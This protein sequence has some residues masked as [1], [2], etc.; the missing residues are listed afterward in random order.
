MEL[1][2]YSFVQEIILQKNEKSH[3]ELNKLARTCDFR[4]STTKKQTW[5]FEGNI[6]CDQNLAY[7]CNILEDIT[8]WIIERIILEFQQKNKHDFSRGIFSEIKT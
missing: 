4:I 3:H 7:E 1:T 5:F 2:L 6:Q 8:N